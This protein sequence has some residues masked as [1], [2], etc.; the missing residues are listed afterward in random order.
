MQRNHNEILKFELFGIK[1]KLKLFQ[2][3]SAVDFISALWT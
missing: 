1:M 2:Q 3:D